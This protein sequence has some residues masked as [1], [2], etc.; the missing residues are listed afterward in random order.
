MKGVRLI[1]NFNSEIK[2]FQNLNSG[3]SCIVKFFL[4]IKYLFLTSKNVSKK[5][6][7]NKNEN[8]Y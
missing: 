7:V 4:D 8:Y 3:F 6:I 1:Y 2:K 5:P